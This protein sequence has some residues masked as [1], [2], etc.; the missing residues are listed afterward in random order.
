MLDLN[1]GYK[2]QQW[3][4]NLGLLRDHIHGHD[5]TMRRTTNGGGPLMSLG[6]VRNKDSEMGIEATC[7]CF[8]SDAM[9]THHDQKQLKTERIYFI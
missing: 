2:D 6:G 7:I 9:L 1:P 4:E 8:L 5:Q 3:G